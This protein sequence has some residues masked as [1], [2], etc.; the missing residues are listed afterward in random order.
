MHVTVFSNLV[1]PAFPILV[2][3]ASLIS[4]R[5][6]V[7]LTDVGISLSLLILMCYR[8]DM[9]DLDRTIF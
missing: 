9:T 2:T 6:C 3:I 4:V 8:N 5:T 7:S 1:I